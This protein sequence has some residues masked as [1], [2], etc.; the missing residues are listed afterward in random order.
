M[1]APMEDDEALLFCPLLTEMVVIMALHTSLS[2]ANDAVVQR[3][4]T[5]M[6]TDTF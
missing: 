2:H 6:H 1:S 5:G 3:G 4:N